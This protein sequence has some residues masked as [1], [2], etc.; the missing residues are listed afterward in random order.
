MLVRVGRL[1]EAE[2]AYARMSASPTLAARAAGFRSLGYLAVWRGRIDEATSKFTLAADATVQ[3]ETPLSEVRNRLLLAWTHRLAGR[4]AAASAEVD[5]VMQLHEATSLEPG[6]LSFI[7]T[8]LV[9]LDRLNDAERVL[10][11][12]RARVDSASDVDRAAE[13]LATGIVELARNRPD[14][15]LHFASRAAVFPQEVL[16]LSLRGD[17][18][19][20]LGQRDSAKAVLRRILA[21]DSFGAEAQEEWHRAHILLGDLLLAEGDTAGAR[22]AYQALVQRW[23]EAPPALPDL[24]AAR[25]RLVALGGTSDR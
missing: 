3:M 2:S 18:Y 16:V 1:A 20:A 22:Q 12:L 6:F 14:S 11:L 19:R 23:R 10:R 25:A 21:A 4:R 13:A 15:A 9:R 8:G 24:V 7:V 5:R 17:A